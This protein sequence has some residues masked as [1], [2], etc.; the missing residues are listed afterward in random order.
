MEALLA[1]P[2]S[3]RRRR[4]YK[5]QQTESFQDQ[6]KGGCEERFTETWF[7]AARKAGASSSSERRTGLGQQ[8]LQ[9]YLQKGGLYAFL[10][11]NALDAR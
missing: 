2:A 3:K 4:Q 10:S 5:L 1:A 8:E 7:V 9:G 11:H 6:G